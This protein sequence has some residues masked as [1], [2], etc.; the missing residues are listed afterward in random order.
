MNFHE[1]TMNLQ[2]SN[3]LQICDF[4]V[5]YTNLS[6]EQGLR[7]AFQEIARARNGMNF[8]YRQRQIY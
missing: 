1:L 3:P 6:M 7:Y 4:L 5:M 2:R 8:F